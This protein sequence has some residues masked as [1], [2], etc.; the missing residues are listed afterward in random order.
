MLARTGA[1]KTDFTVRANDGTTRPRL[2]NHARIPRTATG[3]F[4]STVSRTIAPAS[5][6]TPNSSSATITGVGK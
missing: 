4:S 2:E 3:S 6:A 1:H 5:S